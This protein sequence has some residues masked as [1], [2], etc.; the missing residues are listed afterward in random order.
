M[1]FVSVII[2]TCRT[3]EASV[4][5]IVTNVPKSGH[6][7]A[8][9]VGAAFAVFPGSAADA[10][11]AIAAVVVASVGASVVVV[12]AATAVVI[13]I[14]IDVAIHVDVVIDVVTVDDIRVVDVGVSSLCIVGDDD[15]IIENATISFGN[16]NVSTGSVFFIITD[17]FVH[18]NGG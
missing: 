10:I 17:N 12:A 5:V 15:V 16:N 3:A 11:V 18:S 6:Q 2:I 9:I 14:V 1:T 7:R 4:P 13:V 8:I